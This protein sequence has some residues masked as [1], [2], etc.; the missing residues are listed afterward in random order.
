MNK[1]NWISALLAVMMV[2]SMMACIVV[3]VA[4]EEYTLPSDAVKVTEITE[5]ESGSQNYKITEAADFVWLSTNYATYT[6]TDDVIYIANDI[7]INDY[8]GGKDAFFADF[9]KIPSLLG[10][11]DGLGHTIYNWY[12]SGPLFSNSKQYDSYVKNLTFDGAVV[13]SDDGD[14]TTKPVV[15]VIIGQ[16]D[17]NGSGTRSLLV[18]NVHV[19]NTTVTTT[20]VVYSG[21]MFGGMNTNNM[22]S[23]TIKNCSVINSSITTPTGLQYGVG[24]LIGRIKCGATFTIEDVLMAGCT[25]NGNNKSTEGGGLLVGDI[26]KP[27]TVTAGT[28]T[29]TINNVGIF[30]NTNNIP[31]GSTAGASCAIVTNAYAATPVSITGVYAAGNKVVSDAGTV[32]FATLTASGKNTSLATVGTY[33][34]DSGVAYVKYVNPSYSGTNVEVDANY[35]DSDYAFLNEGIVDAGWGFDT[36]GN[37]VFLADGEK[38]PVAVSFTVDS[39]TTTYYTDVNGNLRV[40]ADE[41]GLPVLADAADITALGESDWK[42]TDGSAVNAGADWSTVVVDEDTAYTKVSLP[43]YTMTL[44]KDTYVKGDIVTATVSLIAGSNLQGVEVG[45]NYDENVLTP[46]ADA[47]GNYAIAANGWLVTDKKE[48]ENMMAVTAAALSGENAT[49]AVDVFSVKFKVTQDLA[50]TAS[51]LAVTAVLEYAGGMVGDTMTELDLEAYT[52]VEIVGAAEIKNNELIDYSHITTPASEAYWGDGVSEYY[53]D[54]VGELIRM[55]MAYVQSRNGHN[56]YSGDGDYVNDHYEPDD[57]IYITADLDMSDWDYEDFATYEDGVGYTPEKIWVAS[58]KVYKYADNTLNYV[59]ETQEELFSALYTGMVLENNSLLGWAAN[60]FTLDGLGHTI[61]NYTAHCP[62]FNGAFVGIIRNLT[63]ENANVTPTYTDESAG[64]IPNAA[65]LVSGSTYLVYKGQ[66]ANTITGWTQNE[67]SLTLDNVHINNSVLTCPAAKTAGLFVNM[68]NAQSGRDKY[69]NIKNCSAINS[70]IIGKDAEAGTFADGVTGYGLLA[71][72]LTTVRTVVDNVIFANC[73]VTQGKDGYNA[74]LIGSGQDSTK[75]WTFSNVA[76][77]N[78]QL[79]S[80]TA[81]AGNVGIISSLLSN[82][83]AGSF[84]NVYAS[85]NTFAT[86]EGG[87]AVPATNLLVYPNAAKNYTATLKMTN[88]VTDA[89]V[90]NA[91]SWTADASKNTAVN[92]NTLASGLAAAVTEL[93]KTIT[94]AHWR[95]NADGSLYLLGQEV[96]FQSNGE[97]DMVRYTDRINE[98]ILYEE[99]EN[100][101]VAVDPA[102]FT[103]LTNNYWYNAEISNPTNEDFIEKGY[104][105]ENETYAKD[106]TYIRVPK[107]SE[108]VKGDAYK[109]YYIETVSDLIGA[110]F[111]HTAAVNS[112]TPEGIQQG[113]VVYITADLDIAD[114]DVSDWAVD[115]GDGTYTTKGYLS[116]IST[117]RYKY[118]A[119]VEGKTVNSKQEVFATMYTGFNSRDARYTHA[120]FDIDGLNHTIDN[121]YAYNAL[122]AGCLSG[123]AVMK[124]LT[125]TNALVDTTKQ[126]SIWT[127]DAAAI[128]VNSTDTYSSS[129]SIGTGAY[130]DNVHIYNSEV[131]KSGGEGAAILVECATNSD[132]KRPPRITNCSIVDCT[133]TGGANVFNYGLFVGEWENA[134]YIKNC[135]AVNSTIEVE[136]IHE[137]GSVSFLGAGSRQNRTSVSEISNV[138]LIGCKIVNA[139]DVASDVALVFSYNEKN[140][141]GVN[142]QAGTKP[143]T[144]Q[145]DGTYLDKNGNL[146]DEDCYLLDENG[147]KIYASE[148][149]TNQEVPLLIKDIYV[150]DCTYTAGANAATPITNLVTSCDN[151]GEKITF[152]NIVADELTNLYYYTGNTLSSHAD[153]VAPEVTV[154]VIA[155]TEDNID[156]SMDIAA[157]VAGLNEE[158][159]AVDWYLDN[160]N[161]VPACA[162]NGTVGERLN[163]GHNDIAEMVNNA[164]SGDTI[165]LCLDQSASVI[166]IPAGVTIELDGYVLD[167]IV[168]GEGY[169]NDNSDGKGGVTGLGTIGAANAQLPLNDKANGVYRLYNFD[170]VPGTDAPVLD[171]NGDEIAHIRKFR[172][173]LNFT[174]EDAYALLAA[175]TSGM[176]LQAAITSEAVDGVVPYT[177]Q[178]VTA[179]AQAIVDNPTKSYSLVLKVYGVDAV[180]GNNLNITYNVTSAGVAKAADA[181]PYAVPAVEA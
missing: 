40:T 120:G 18:E 165:K 57:V 72:R 102:L 17:G 135:I 36:K 162:M 69:V 68:V 141:M 31:T 130:L 144:E 104:D 103:K 78:C 39:E 44:D 121:Y 155:A 7:D 98:H 109:T 174:N 77:V 161:Y 128:A 133:V 4:A 71:G 114:W 22:K 6:D 76:V 46:V 92:D 67:F 42:A 33:K 160:G 176:T 96:T 159:A 50:S 136:S 110:S 138:A 34:V 59:Y 47:E 48:S 41:N 8:E 108:A 100:G 85:G 63:F 167:A 27:S 14:S 93:E 49:E 26:N 29:V 15:G 148:Q 143:A 65:I 178:N 73:S 140:T 19:K 2:I 55:N 172:L 119:T 173:K 66:A 10:S 150:A 157:A 126:D 94:E 139:A 25:I 117:T 45:F 53:I 116:K 89:N 125:F 106:V 132:V 113:E 86:A 11:V 83:H 9:V 95:V 156:T 32:P 147:K 127:S 20:D 3:P 58:G 154:D 112:N 169:V 5:K 21:I 99:T 81:T 142:Y 163:V 74:M 137:N 177:F 111:A 88:I 134:G 158:V 43:P 164:K 168:G 123:G 145:A 82:T 179:Y 56:S 170:V 101:F 149:V 51:E 131:I 23:V 24:G 87:A 171:E 28:T 16:L 153:A 105:W 75:Y 90:T 12:A 115:N 124:N 13:V 52:T 152:N 64:Y 79:I 129:E 91:I 30:N 61:Y 38:A 151:N 1:R 122:I 84:T 37:M 35:V 80:S 118:D 180:A 62:F 166:T 60:R 175:G 107:A 146:V 181:T 54:S 70:H 97:E